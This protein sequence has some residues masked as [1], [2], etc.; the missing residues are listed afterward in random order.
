MTLRNDLNHR[1]PGAGL[2]A[3]KADCL[4]LALVPIEGAGTYSRTMSK[5]WVEQASLYVVATPIGNRAD[6]SQ[7]ACEVLGECDLIACEDTRTTGT[8]LKASGISTPLVS[9]HEHNEKERA[10][11]LVDKLKDG[12]AIALVSDAGTPAISDPGFRLVRACRREALPVY[13]VPG[14]SAV[15]AALSISGLPSDRFFYTGFLPP[16]G[17]ARRRFLESHIGADFSLLVFESKH[18]IEKFLEEIESIMG[19]NRVVSLSRE[20][21]KLHE[22]SLTAPIAD[23]RRSFEGQSHKGEFVVI[24]A[25]ADFKL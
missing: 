10:H 1:C 14:P 16:R 9:Y 15:T 20:M 21:S 22:T 11:E 13:T 18:R 25:P 23:L 24:I 8:L 3:G 5:R 17:A 12:A 19:A 7:R 4:V 2:P 6:F